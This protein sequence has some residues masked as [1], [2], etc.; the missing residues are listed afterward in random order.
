MSLCSVMYYFSSASHLHWVFCYAPEAASVFPCS[1]PVALD[2]YVGCFFKELFL[3]PWS[4]W[5]VLAVRSPGQPVFAFLPRSSW[6]K[7]PV[8]HRS[9]A[10]VWSLHKGR[11]WALCINY[12]MYQRITHS[13]SDIKKEE[14]LEPTQMFMNRQMDKLWHIHLMEHNST[15]KRNKLPVYPTIWRSLKN[16]LEERKQRQKEY[17]LYDSICRKFEG[18]RNLSTVIASRPVVCLGLGMGGRHWIQ[19]GRRQL[20]GIMELLPWLGCWLC[21]YIHLSNLIQL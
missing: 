11:G 5:G 4:K 7:L 2:S 16:M 1:L 8:Q 14:K 15:I 12:K 3:K 19:R 18:R 20:W 17:I 10:L 9:P 21:G 13:I 6:L